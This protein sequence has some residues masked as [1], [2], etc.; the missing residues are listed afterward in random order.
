VDFSKSFRYIGVV[1]AEEHSMKRSSFLDAASW[2]KRIADLDRRER[3][4][5]LHR[6]P[7]RFAKVLSYLTYVRHF[8]SLESCNSFIQSVRPVVVL[9]DDSL[10][11]LLDFRPKVRESNIAERHRKV[12]TI[13][14]DNIAYYAYWA[15]EVRKK[16]QLI[17]LILK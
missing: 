4:A 8:S 2:A 14:A 7:H 9:V 11:D 17:Q 16:P 1:V 13:L 6:F 10:Y 12:L 3:I 15:T 5:Y